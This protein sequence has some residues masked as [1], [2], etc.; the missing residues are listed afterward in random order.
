M[1][2]FALITPTEVEDSES[3]QSV[4]N[5]LRECRLPSDDL[6]LDDSIYVRYEDSNGR[7]IGTAGLE[8]YFPFALL[9]SVAVSE[10]QRGRSIGRQIV[11]D[12][13]RRSEAKSLKAV[14]ILTETAHD[15]FARNGFKDVARDNVP[16][17]V[18][19][20]SEFTSVC[21]VS[22]ACMVY[23]LPK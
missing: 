11:T 14:Y 4:R 21:P 9:R 19:A 15:F 10:L 7:L 12:M 8:I 22:A 17:Q 2:D 6:H 3:L 23:Q 20:S 5:L 18:S 1:K 16:A 13:L